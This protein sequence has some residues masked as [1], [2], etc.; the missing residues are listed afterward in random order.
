MRRIFVV[1][2]GNFGAWVSRT[3][4]ELGHEVIAI[5]RDG[6]LVD[7]Y[8]D[9]TTRAVQGDAT[10]PTVL[11][12][13]GAASAD[14]AVISTGE[15]LATTILATV[16]LRDLGVREIYAKVGSPNEARALEALDVTDEIFPEREAGVR[17]AHRLNARGVLEYVPLDPTHSIQEL[18]IPPDWI[19]RTLR[20]IAPREALGIQVVGVRCALSDKLTV[21]PDPAARFKDSDA[22]IVAG[23]DAVL[24]RL[25]GGKARR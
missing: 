16:A 14:A 21:P 1:G 17:L 11:Q 9:W 7:R 13:A 23:P 25:T 24:Q 2:L 18:A 10:D 8:A 15:D 20:E 12:R 22:A 3:L 6:A 5:E 19:G 4:R